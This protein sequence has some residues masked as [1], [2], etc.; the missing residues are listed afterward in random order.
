MLARALE[1]L[2]ERRL[3]VGDIEEAPNAYS[4]SKSAS[5]FLNEQ[6]SR[7]SSLQEGSSMVSLLPKIVL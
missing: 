2:N 6:W 3:T 5:P 7:R 4:I 1:E